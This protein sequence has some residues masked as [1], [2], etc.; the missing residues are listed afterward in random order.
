VRAGLARASV[1]LEH[2][3]IQ[4]R[5]SSVFSWKCTRDADP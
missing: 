3:I 4:R 5:F 1:P 2:P